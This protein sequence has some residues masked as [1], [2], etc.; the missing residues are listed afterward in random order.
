MRLPAFY[1]RWKLER[2]V[3]QHARLTG[4]FINVLG[5]TNPTAAG[6]LWHRLIELSNTPGI[7]PIDLMQQ[8]NQL[9]ADAQKAEA[10]RLA[11]RG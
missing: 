2:M 8:A 5:Q 11:Q 6:V 1:R 3:R 10:L 7:D 4:D 9:C